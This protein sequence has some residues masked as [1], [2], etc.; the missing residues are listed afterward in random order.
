MFLPSVERYSTLAWAPTASLPSTV[1]LSSTRNLTVLASLFFA[2]CTENSA[3]PTDVICPDKDWLSGVGSRGPAAG[4]AAG[5]VDQAA[6]VKQT[7]KSDARHRDARNRMVVS[8]NL[9]WT[10]TEAS[11]TNKTKAEESSNFRATACEIK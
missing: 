1:V 8:S 6:I 9:T 2:T 5:G 4:W 3:S 10:G 11:R 7:R